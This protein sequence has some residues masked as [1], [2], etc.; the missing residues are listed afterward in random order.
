VKD[1]EGLLGADLQNRDCLL[2]FWIFVT[3]MLVK[4]LA[5]SPKILNAG[6]GCTSSS[7]IL[8]EKLTVSR[9]VIKIPLLLRNPEVHD[10]V[11]KSQI[12]VPAL[13]RDNV[14]IHLSI[15]PLSTPIFPKWS[16]P[17]PG[18]SFPGQNFICTP[19]PHHSCYTHVPSS[20]PWCDDP[21]NV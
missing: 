6:F 12:L 3:L 11:Y 20:P 5:I 1:S 4:A 13:S 7:G 15:V 21:N 8:P 16:P 2:H 18:P 9:L 14:H 19:K 17:P 10:R